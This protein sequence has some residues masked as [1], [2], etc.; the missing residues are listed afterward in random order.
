MTVKSRCLPPSP[1]GTWIVLLVPNATLLLAPAPA[2]HL[3][4]HLLRGIDHRAKAA[5]VLVGM[6]PA[7][8]TRTRLLVAEY[9]VRFVDLAKRFTCVGRAGVG[10]MLASELAKRALDL[11]LGRVPLDA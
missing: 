8:V 6:A 2:Q 9:G 7:I 5:R 11:G 4:D 10:V 1:L 3:V